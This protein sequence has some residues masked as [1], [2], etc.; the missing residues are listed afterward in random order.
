MSALVFS[1]WSLARPQLSWPHL[2]TSATQALTVKAVVQ[3]GNSECEEE[4]GED[5]PS[6]DS[7]RERDFEEYD[8]RTFSAETAEL[9]SRGWTAFVI[10]VAEPHQ[11]MQS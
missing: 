8:A 7:E 5:G 3:S 11:A 6:D 1:D 10:G 4:E 2:S 9:L